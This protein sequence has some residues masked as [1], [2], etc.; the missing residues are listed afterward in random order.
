MGGHLQ[1]HKEWVLLSHRDCPTHGEGE[2]TAMGTDPSAG[3]CP[4]R[5]AALATPF[6][7]EHAPCTQHQACAVWVLL[8]KFSWEEGIRHAQV[9]CRCM[10]GLELEPRC[11]CS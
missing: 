3:G 9:L 4:P 1:Q 5:P 2:S 11:V 10:P 8:F 7:L 6:F